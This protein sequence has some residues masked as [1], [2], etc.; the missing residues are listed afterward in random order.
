LEY[1]IL[2]K[3][4]PMLKDFC[5]RKHKIYLLL[6]VLGS[7]LEA[8]TEYLYQ[9]GFSPAAIQRRLHVTPYIDHDLQKRHCYSI[10]DLTRVVLH[11]CNPMSRESQTKIEISATIRLLERYLDSCGILQPKKLST[12][13]HRLTDYRRYLYEERGFS[14]PTVRAHCLIITRFIT[15]FSKKGGWSYLYKITSKDIEYFLRDS[16]TKVGR[17][18]LRHMATYIRSF[19]RF[20]VLHGEIPAGIDKQVDIPNVY[21]EEKLP[22]TLAWNTVQALLNSIDRTTA[23]GKRDYAMLLLITTYGLRASEITRLTLDDIEWRTH[24]L[25]IFQNKT[26]SMLLLP[27][28]NAVG[29]SIIEYLTK[30]RPEAHCREIFVRHRTPSGTLKPTAV[31]E[32]FQAWSRRS[33][34]QIPFQGAHCIRHSFAVHLLRQGTSLKTIGDMLGHR[35]LQSTCVY[36][37]LNIEDLRTVAL[38]IPVLS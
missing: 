5:K 23:L 14:T 11:R 34:L 8:F 18:R 27:L 17:D 30:G 3:E 36:L 10:N 38:C 35:D 13:E 21:R 19:L 37:R 22:R 6:P 26:S 20:L 15:R 32:V 33:G 25:Q 24:R 31:S 1:L 28:T 2:F 16:A 7:I 12:I 9:L 29:E 4:I